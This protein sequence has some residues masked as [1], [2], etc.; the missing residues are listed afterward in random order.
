MSF[1]T[2]ACRLN[3]ARVCRL[4]GGV[5]ELMFWGAAVC[6]SST[7]RGLHLALGESPQVPRPP[8]SRYDI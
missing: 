6:E 7:H 5:D 1:S 3:S 2:T 8:V 4:A